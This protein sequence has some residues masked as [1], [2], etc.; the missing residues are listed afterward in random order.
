MSERPQPTAQIAAVPTT[1]PF[2]A[3]EELARRAG[4]SSLLRLGANE[5]AFGP[6]PRSLEAMHAG[7]QRT[8]WYGDPESRE[9]REAL[10][11][12]HRCSPSQL[13]VASGIDDIL[14]LVVRAYM[15]PGGTALATLG[16]YPTFAFHVAGYGGRL[17][18]VPYED[19]GTVPLD[20]LA[21]RAGELQ[22]QIIYVA[23]PDNPS[24]SFA[25]AGTLERC[26]AALPR[27]TLLLLDE[28]YA[29]FVE[30][31]ELLRPAVRDGVIRART[32][33]KAFGLAGARIAYALATDEVGATL[34]KIR[35][36]YGVN[37]T[38]QLA[39]LAALEDEPFVRSVVAEVARGRDE[40]AALGTRLKIATL[41]SHTNFVCFDLGSRERAEAMV[42]E[43][44]HR[45]VFIRKPGAPP[46]D[47]FVRVT[48]G[49]PAE[50]DR[51]AAVF[52]EAL[53]A[54]GSRSAWSF[55]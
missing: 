24:G 55:V 29:D 7:L 43:L 45:G 26:L 12:R 22:P 31:C 15:P 5:S 42:D 48:V 17:E 21:A 46:L 37:R 35:L 1:T 53:S 36:H 6:P 41:P 51:F 28:A 52:E 54:L 38:A 30:E 33:S 4:H 39:A 47:R 18:T 44:L 8:S 40:Y 32:F 49:T 2:V 9:L 19:D 34:Q 16:T 23:N 10:G 13:T 11:K 20:R 50:R 25:E 14:G 3:P 27:T